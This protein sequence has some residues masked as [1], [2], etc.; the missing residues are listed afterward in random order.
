MEFFVNTS[1]EPE[2]NLKAKLAI[3]SK[4]NLSL[5]EMLDRIEIHNEQLKLKLQETIC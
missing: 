5:V 4:F 3:V 1:R 2:T